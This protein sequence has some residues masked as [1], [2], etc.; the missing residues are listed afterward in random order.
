METLRR[1]LL[2]YENL[3]LAKICDVVNSNTCCVMPRICKDVYI[4][5]P[6]IFVWILYSRDLSRIA[7]DDLDRVVDAGLQRSYSK[8]HH[9][10]DRSWL[11]P[12]DSLL[13]RLQV[14]AVQPFEIL[15]AKIETDGDFPSTYH[16]RILELAH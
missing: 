4:K 5:K 3:P 16:F 2:K 15:E 11:T 9:Y 6:G 14:E 12:A 1:E 13:K 10:S 8:K 7:P